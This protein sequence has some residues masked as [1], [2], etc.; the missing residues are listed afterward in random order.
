M[1]TLANAKIKPFDVIYCLIKMKLSYWFLCVAKS[2]DWS[3]KITPL[4]NLTR[5][6]ASRG[7]KTYSE[8]RIELQNLQILK[9]ILENSSQFLSSEQP[10]EPKSLD[11]ALKFTGVEKFARKT[12][13]CGQPGG[14][15]IRVLNVRGVNGGGNLCPL[16]LVILKSV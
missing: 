15:S 9:K 1:P 3:K 7:M 5:K 16:L 10:C 11:V 12:H 6:V 13:G 14:H 4:S 2:C 8:I